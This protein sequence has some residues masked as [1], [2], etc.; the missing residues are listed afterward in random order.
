MI[1][2]VQRLTVLLMHC[3]LT[4]CYRGCMAVARHT[5]AVNYLQKALA[6]YNTAPT[7]PLTAAVIASAKLTAAAAAAQQASLQSSSSTA[8][9]QVQLTHFTLNRVHRLLAQCLCNSG[10]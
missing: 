6:L 3:I 1:V 2:T 8:S 9:L 4:V 7:A 5:E 10:F